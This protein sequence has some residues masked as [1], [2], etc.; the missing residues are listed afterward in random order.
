MATKR[1]GGGVLGEFSKTPT[2]VVELPPA[3][4]FS[5]TP[6]RQRSQH[7]WWSRPRGHHLRSP[8]KTT[9]RPPLSANPPR[10][11]IAHPRNRPRAPIA[12][13]RNSPRAPIAHPRNGPRAPIAHPCSP[14][15]MPNETSRSQRSGGRCWT[16]P[17]RCRQTPA[18]QP[19]FGRP[20]HLTILLRGAQSRTLHR[21][22]SPV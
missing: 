5:K 13:P 22:E 8:T 15:A 14:T 16:Q 7:L 6:D 3:P 17:Q 21:C 20:V 1:V 2:V 12:H 4:T 10:A 18:R 19:S 9:R 11:P